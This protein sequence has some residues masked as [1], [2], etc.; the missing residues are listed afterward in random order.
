MKCL[1]LRFSQIVAII[2]EKVIL[3]KQNDRFLVFYQ[4]LVKLI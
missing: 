1:L 3:E 4:V 2:P